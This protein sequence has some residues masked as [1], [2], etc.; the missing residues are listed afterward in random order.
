MEFV[1]SDPKPPACCPF[2]SERV[3]CRRGPLA[4][5][6][7]ILTEFG[8]KTPK[9]LETSHTLSEA[10]GP[11]GLDNVQ[12]HGPKGAQTSR[13]LPVVVPVHGKPQAQTRSALTSVG[14][15][16]RWQAQRFLGT[17]QAPFGTSRQPLVRVRP[18]ARHDPGLPHSPQAARYRLCGWD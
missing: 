7:R 13:P 14:A 5:V 2:G 4:R 12:P 10:P 16:V 8:D 15:A 17:S 3:G 1:A 11:K 9:G 18:P 6:P